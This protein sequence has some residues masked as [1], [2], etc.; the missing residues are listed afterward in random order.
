M[1]KAWEIL[2]NF[3]NTYGW[4]RDETSGRYLDEILHEDLD[5]IVQRY[6]YNNEMRYQKYFE[7]RGTFFLDAGC[8]AEPRLKMSQNFQRHVCIDISI[9]GLKEARKRL[10]DSGLYVVA[11]MVSLPF[12]EKTFDGVLASHCLYHIDK[13]LQTIALRELY[14]VAKD[15]KNILIF[16]ISKYSMIS[17]VRKVGKFMIRLTDSLFKA[18]KCD[19]RCSGLAVRIPPPLYHYVHNPFKLIK[20]FKLAD[21]TCL[22]TLSARE[23]KLLKKLHLL[24]PFII[25]LSYLEKKFPHSMVYIGSY[26]AIRIKRT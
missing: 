19:R 16:Y 13:D 24:K 26:V 18:L 6:M 9:V 1:K 11:D 7:K 20:E 8:G 14:R 3:Y 5:E 2:R 12:K 23:T 17:I 4:K 21:V 25:V 22:R 15:N 10:R